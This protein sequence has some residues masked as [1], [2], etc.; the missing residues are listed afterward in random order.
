[1]LEFRA[2]LE[3]SQV[4]LEVWLF[5]QLCPG[6]EKAEGAWRLLGGLTLSCRE[7]CKHG[8]AWGWAGLLNGGSSSVE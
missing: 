2:V 8:A 3:S 4:P 7:P 6:T 5:L 1:M